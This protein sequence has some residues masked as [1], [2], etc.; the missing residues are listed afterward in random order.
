[1]EVSGQLHTPAALP[2]GKSPWFQSRSGHGDEEK[3]SQ[4][5]TALEHPIIQP[6]AQ[7]CTAEQTAAGIVILR[8]RESELKCALLS[9][10]R[11]TEHI[12]DGERKEWNT[13]HIWS[14]N[15]AK[16]SICNTLSLFLAEKCLQL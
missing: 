11:S 13:L 10:R 6:V 9:T 15:S 14:A 4:L 3:N 12:S 8:I 7:R 2:Q 5:P 16:Y 1:M